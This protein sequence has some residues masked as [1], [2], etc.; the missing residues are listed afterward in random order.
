M[1]DARKGQITITRGDTGLLAIAPT[2]YVPTS[3][4][5]MFFMVA[6]MPDGRATVGMIQIQPNSRNVIAG[7]AWFSVE[8]RHPSEE[9]LERMAQKLHQAITEIASQL[10][11]SAQIKPVLSFPPVYFDQMCIDTVRETTQSLGYPCQDIVSGAGHDAC[12]LN[13]IA[14]TSMIFIP[15]IGGLSHNE[16]EDITPEW[17]NAGAHVLLHSLL[18]L[19]Q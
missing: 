12:S 14:P 6:E 4:D 7:E 17:G 10:N 5:R 9:A 19:S 8:F 3:Q 15:C 13:H 11:L 18:A 1:F 2:G 16:A